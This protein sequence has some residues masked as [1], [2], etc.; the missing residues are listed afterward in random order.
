MSDEHDHY[1]QED[2]SEDKRPGCTKCCNTMCCCCVFTGR[3][4]V[5]CIGP[6]LRKISTNFGKFLKFSLNKVQCTGQTFDQ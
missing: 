5:R 4:F 3:M 6:Y 1:H 2:S